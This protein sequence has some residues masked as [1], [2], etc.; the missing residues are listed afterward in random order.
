MVERQFAIL[1][2]AGSNPVSRSIFIGGIAKSGKAEDCKSFIPRFKSG[3]RL[4]FTIKFCR[5]GGIGRRIGLKIR[6]AIFAR[7]GSSP[8]PGTMPYRKNNI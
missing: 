6:W 7:V 3:C 5:D 2:V 8:T 4:H 1:E